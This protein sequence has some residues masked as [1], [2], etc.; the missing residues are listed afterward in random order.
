MKPPSG[1]CNGDYGAVD[2]SDNNNVTPAVSVSVVG[3]LAALAAAHSGWTRA[4]LGDLAEL[5]MVLSPPATAQSAPS[6]LD[7]GVSDT[8]A[9]PSWKLRTCLST[10][11]I[12]YGA[13]GWRSGALP[14]GPT[15]KHTKCCSSP[16]GIL[17]RTDEGP[18]RRLSRGPTPIEQFYRATASSLTSAARLQ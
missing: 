5:Q 12:Y 8:E 11:T 1:E 15:T 9:S 4:G 14:S 18:H 13:F 2:I 17:P 3:R 16:S 6:N 7:R 10:Y